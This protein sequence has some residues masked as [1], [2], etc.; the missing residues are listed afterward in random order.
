MINMID[1]RSRK[2]LLY[3]TVHKIAHK[4]SNLPN[5]PLPPPP[6]VVGR[7]GG[8]T[9]VDPWGQNIFRNKLPTYVHNVCN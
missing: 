7:E 2:P 6:S 4:I 1:F 3:K 5:R 8:D 9:G